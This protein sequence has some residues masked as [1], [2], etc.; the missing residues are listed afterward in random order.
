MERR[1]QNPTSPKD[2]GSSLDNSTNRNPSDIVCNAS[3]AEVSDKCDQECQADFFVLCN[4]FEKTFTCNRYIYGSNMCDA[5]IQTEI[6]EPTGA[7]I[8]NN[9]KKNQKQR[10]LHNAKSYCR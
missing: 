5:E 10:M 9:T 4:E 3:V 6:S 8:V 1:M 7:L 2:V